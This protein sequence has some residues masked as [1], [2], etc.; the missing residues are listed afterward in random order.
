MK[1]WFMGNP[2]TVASREELWCICGSSDT[3]GSGVLVW[4]PDEEY[5][6]YAYDLMK[7][8]ADFTNLHYEKYS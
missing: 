7:D 5:A 6:K 4:C 3:Y 8:D 1:Y 2:I